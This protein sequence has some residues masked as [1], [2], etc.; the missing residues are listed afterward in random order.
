MQPFPERLQGYTRELSP[1]EFHRFLEPGNQMGKLNPLGGTDFTDT[2]MVKVATHTGDPRNGDF[3]V[4]KEG[5]IRVSQHPEFDGIDGLP[6]SADRP[7]RGRKVALWGIPS[8]QGGSLFGGVTR[9]LVL[10]LG[11]TETAGQ[12]VD[13]RS[14]KQQSLHLF[15][16]NQVGERDLPLGDSPGTLLAAATL[17]AGLGSFHLRSARRTPLCSCLTRAATCWRK[18]GMV[19]KPIRRVPNK[20]ELAHRQ[21]VQAVHHRGNL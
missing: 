9:S 10:A 18:P 17:W 20:S 16:Y 21:V 19:S 13:G 15:C 7:V 14:A 1:S 4:Y 3:Q 12:G 8:R 2:D 11:I 6:A 5:A